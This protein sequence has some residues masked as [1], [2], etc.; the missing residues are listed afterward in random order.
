MNFDYHSEWLNSTKFIIFGAGNLGKWLVEIYSHYKFFQCFI[1]NDI[2]KQKSGYMG[3]M[4][5][6]FEVYMQ[7][8]YPNNYKIILTCSEENRQILENQMIIAGLKPNRDFLYVKDFLPFFKKNLPIFALNICNENYMYLSQIS[9]TER[10]TLKCKKCC[11]GCYNVPKNAK[12]LTLEEVKESADY[13]FKNIDYVE[14]FYL[15]GGEPFLYMDLKNVIIYI[16]ENYRKQINHCF[17][18]TNGTIIPKLDILELLKQYN[19]GI[20]ISNYSNTISY[21]K[22]KYE[23]IIQ[24]LVENKV[25]YLY[26]HNF[27]WED[28]GFDYVDRGYF[29]ST[30]DPEIR[31]ENLKKIFTKCKTPCREVRKNKLYYCVMARSS[32]ENLGF[33]IGQDDYLDLSKLDKTYKSKKMLTDFEMGI[34][35]KGY[36]DMCNYCNGADRSNFPIPAGEQMK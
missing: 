17:I 32:A 10:C 22:P 8:Y 13:F 16:G 30:I 28:Y 20:Q 9:L 15:L 33:N 18:T 4:V 25:D 1:D 19:I 27:M 35:P 14:T 6:S 31:K 5:L 23:K 24:L 21:L 26:N 3:Y 2:S 34:I 12:D 36:L 11:H 7:K 29:K